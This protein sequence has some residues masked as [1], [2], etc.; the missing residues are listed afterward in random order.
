MTDLIYAT[1]HEVTTL[2]P[3]QVSG[4]ADHTA[5]LAIFGSLVFNFDGKTGAVGYRPWLAESVEA[6]SPKCWVVRLRDGMRFHDGTEFDAEALKFSFDRIRAPGFPAKR[7]FSSAP[8]SSVEVRDRLTCAV[9]TSEPI[10]AFQARLLRADGSV[11][12]P[13][14][15]VGD[16][17][18]T[19]F[20]PVG[21]GPFRFENYIK[22]DRLELGVFDGFEDPRGYPRPNFERLVMRVIADPDQLFSEFEGGRVDIAPITPDQTEA[23]GG[24]DGVRII[25]ASDTSRMSLEINQAA[26]PALRDKRVRQAINHAIDV[27]TLLCEL[28]GGAGQRIVSL[29]N[30]PNENASIAPYAYDTDRARALLAEA[31]HDGGFELEIDWSTARDRG[32]L[33]E[34][35]VPYLEAVGIRVSRVSELDW[36]GEYKP[37]QTEGTLGGLH[38]HGHAGVEMTAETDLWPIH[39]VREDNSTNWSGPQADRFC[40]VYS[41][42]QRTVDA[43]GQRRLGDELQAIT[44]EEAISVPFW[45]LPRFVAVGARVAHFAPYPGGHNEDFWTVRMSDAADGGQR[46]T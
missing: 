25:S 1:A 23:F 26:H 44:H 29:V 3:T 31:G 18:E 40:E 42:L 46:K 45:Q 34:A 7:Y 2:E 8:I 17:A 36:G 16:P 38:G 33:A 4:F 22:G 9:H 43:E 24:I 28:T 20:D 21:A 41:E 10:A 6:V 39:P 5:A 37:R 13:G 30:P 14:H 32:K 12:A 11:V 35:V 19:A 15:Y 27:E